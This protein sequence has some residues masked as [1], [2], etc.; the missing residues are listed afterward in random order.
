MA[1]VSVH[2]FEAYILANKVEQKSCLGGHHIAATG[3][4]TIH[5]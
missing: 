2:D 1:S 5:Y 3:L 4:P